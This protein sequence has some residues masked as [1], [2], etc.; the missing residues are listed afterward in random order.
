MIQI[1]K[2][3][4]SIKGNFAIQ[5]LISGIENLNYLCKL[6]DIK[7]TQTNYENYSRLVV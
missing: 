1:Q 7:Y 2:A 5:N 6:A 4:K 3:N